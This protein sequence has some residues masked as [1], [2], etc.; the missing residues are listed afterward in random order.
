MN[1]GILC[2]MHTKAIQNQRKSNSDKH[3]VV[4]NQHEINF[5]NLIAYILCLPTTTIKLNCTKLSELFSIKVA[6][7]VRVTFS[8]F[9]FG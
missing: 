2:H 3:C 8:F 7:V 1:V 5:L 6:Q 9:I 4:F